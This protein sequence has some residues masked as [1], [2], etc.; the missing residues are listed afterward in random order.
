MTRQTWKGCWWNREARQHASVFL[1]VGVS[2]SFISWH[3]EYYIV[4]EYK[5]YANVEFL[6]KW[7]RNNPKLMTNFVVLLLQFQI[8]NLLLHP[9]PQTAPSEGGSLGSNRQQPTLSCV[10]QQRLLLE[11]KS[12]QQE[13]SLANGKSLSFY[14][15]LRL[16]FCTN[17]LSIL[18]LAFIGVLLF[19]APPG[20]SYRR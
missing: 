4:D 17:W 9:L 15:I 10:H 1:H 6:Q 7:K 11:A 18:G 13:E 3:V 14:F 8:P 16:Y 20:S 19:L 2:S 12:R 5:R